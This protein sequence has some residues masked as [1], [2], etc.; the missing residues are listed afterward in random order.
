MLWVQL[1]LISAYSGGFGAC[2]CAAVHYMG[3][4]DV[5][6]GIKYSTA[7][8]G[9]AEAFPVACIANNAPQ[10][11]SATTGKSD[12]ISVAMFV[13]NIQLMLDSYKK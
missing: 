13:V 10:F 6:V 4:L 5:S 7:T 9:H 11:K 2:L 1:L 3:V 12:V 8:L